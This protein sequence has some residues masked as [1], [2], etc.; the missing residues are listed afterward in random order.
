MPVTKPK[1]LMKHYFGL[2]HQKN[3]QQEENHGKIPEVI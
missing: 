1:I 3:W 2:D